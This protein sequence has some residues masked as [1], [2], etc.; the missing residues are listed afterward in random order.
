MHLSIRSFQLPAN[1]TKSIA[2]DMPENMVDL[3]KDRYKSIMVSAMLFN[4][5]LNYS[6]YI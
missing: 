6:S 2:R 1:F 5:R 3:T 4:C